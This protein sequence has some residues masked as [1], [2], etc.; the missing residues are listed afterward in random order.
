[1][2]S[3]YE[4]LIHVKSSG[5]MPLCRPKEGHR[6]QVAVFVEDWIALDPNLRCK[7][8]VQ[9]MSRS[10]PLQRNGWTGKRQCPLDPELPSTVAQSAAPD[11]SDD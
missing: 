5:G 4:F 3:H 9:L 11:G 10:R 7:L 6:A 8:C 2:V 1:M